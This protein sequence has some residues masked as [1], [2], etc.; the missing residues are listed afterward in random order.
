M[1]EYPIKVSPGGSKTYVKSV[2]MTYEGDG[3]RYRTKRTVTLNLGIDTAPILDA[4]PA[5][6]TLATAAPQ[7]RKRAPR[8]TVD[9]LQATAVAL[10]QT[11]EQLL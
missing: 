1:V 4:L 6:A 7:Q 2:S 3:I 10:A 5:A 8:S 9:Q 11:T